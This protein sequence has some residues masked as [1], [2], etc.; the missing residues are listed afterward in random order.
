MVVLGLIMHVILV[1]FYVVVKWLLY[2][3]KINYLQLCE[4]RIADLLQGKT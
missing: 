4:S 2:L 3:E 1:Y